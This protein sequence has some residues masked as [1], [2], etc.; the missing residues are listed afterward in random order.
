MTDLVTFGE[1]PLRLSTPGHTRL[2]TASQADIYVDGEESSVAVAA[3]CLGAECTWLSKLPDTPIGR[4]IVADL[5]RHGIETDVTWTDEGRVGLVYHEAGSDPRPEGRWHDREHT[6]AATAVPGDLPMDLVQQA[7]AVFTGAST[8]ALSEEAAETTEAIM[9]A[10]GSGESVAALDLDYDQALHDAE[11]MGRLLDRLF[12]H[13]DLFVAN[14]A[15]ARTVLDLT[16]GPRELANTIVAEYDLEMVLITRSQYGAVVMHDTP[17]TN[18]IHERD[19]VEAAPIDPTGQ[20]EALVGGFL[21]RIADGADA[22]QAL[23]AAVATASLARTV[24]GPLLEA[25]EDEIDAIAEQVRE[26]S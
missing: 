3:S 15:D 7:D 13:V 24:P 21:A 14:E 26:S 20:H 12:A 4:R 16:G 5:R 8:P 23:T 10:G 6:S 25:T 17:G 11:F 9:R 18:V 2:E 22:A 19:T 1:T